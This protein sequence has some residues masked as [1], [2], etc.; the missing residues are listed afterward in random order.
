MTATIE[1]VDIHAHGVPARFLESVRKSGLAGAK[2]DVSEGRYV[3]TFPG[4]APLRPVAGVMLEFEQRLKWLDDQGMQHQIVAPWLDVDGQ[5][6]PDADG[7]EWAR[8]LNDALAE[9]VAATGGRLR[10]HAT[11]H[12]ADEKVAA[13]ELERASRLGM[14]A[15]MMRTNLPRGNLA[16]ARY[17]A[18][19]EAAQA[20]RVPIVLHPP[21]DGPSTCMFEEKPKFRGLFGRLIDTTVVAMEL[22][23]A[24]VLARFPDLQLVLVH[25]GGFLPYQTGRMDREAE[26]GK[27]PSDYVKRFYYDTVLMSPVA[28]K[29]LLEFI[30]AGRVMIGSDYGAA[31]KERGG[32]KLTDALDAIGPDP[33]TRRK[34]VRE[35]AERLFRIGK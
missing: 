32:L 17:D 25:G 15:C 35:T 4:M 21:T 10:A 31:A 24:G 5:E 29:L 6:L 1:G 8:Q 33:A 7:Q 12:M 11:L 3:L 14:T 23:Q 18:V 27:L 26:K 34:V 22:I 20:L 30:G 28:L 2:V 9:A 16:E 19:W 13:R